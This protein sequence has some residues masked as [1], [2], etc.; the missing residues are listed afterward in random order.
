MFHIIIS[1]GGGTMNE[2]TDIKIYRSGEKPPEGTYACMSCETDTVAYI[3]PE[4]A[5]ELPICPQCQ[6]TEWMKV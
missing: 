6:G 2:D 4:M 1:E 3:V 5:E